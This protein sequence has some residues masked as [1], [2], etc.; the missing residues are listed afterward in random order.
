MRLPPG[1]ELALAATLVMVLSVTLVLVA[2]LV[3]TLHLF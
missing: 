3:P 1:F 2:V